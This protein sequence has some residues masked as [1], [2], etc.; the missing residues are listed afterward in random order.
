MPRAKKLKL[1]LIKGI[2]PAAKC[3]SMDDY[4]KFIRLNLKYLIDKRAVRKQKKLGA[5]NV[6]F[7]LKQ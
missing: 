3:L 5:V 6:A 2:L 1:P 4:V 7:S